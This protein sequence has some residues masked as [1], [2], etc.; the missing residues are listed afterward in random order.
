MVLSAKPEELPLIEPNLA[1]IDMSGAMRFEQISLIGRVGHA[2]G[3]EYPLL[4]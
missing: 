2:S 3:G 1:K 4:G